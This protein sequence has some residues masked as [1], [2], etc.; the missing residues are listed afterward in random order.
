MSVLYH[1][2][3]AGKTWPGHGVRHP[4]ASADLLLRPVRPAGP[5]PQCPRG[6]QGLCLGASD[7]QHRG[8]RRPGDVHHP[9]GQQ[10]GCP[11]FDRQLLRPDADPGRQCN[12]GYRAAIAGPARPLKKLGLGL[13]PRFDYAEWACGLLV[14]RRLDH[15]HHG[16]GKP[17]LPAHW[18]DR[19]HS[20]RGQTGRHHSRGGGH[21]RT[22]RPQPCHRGLHPAA[23]GGRPVHRHGALHPHGAGRFRP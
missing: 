3:L 16:G 8:H 11:A 17:D 20:D 5:G 2:L 19:H 10:P 15:G 22:L 14:D 18:K 21:C 23:L 9:C 13:R 1:R 4:A 12:P 6:I 7:K